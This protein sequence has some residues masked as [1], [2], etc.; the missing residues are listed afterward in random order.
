MWHERKNEAE[1]YWDAPN[2]SK[3]RRR[4]K[5]RDWEGMQLRAGEIHVVRHS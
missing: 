5:S 2:G 3:E 4:G 1:K